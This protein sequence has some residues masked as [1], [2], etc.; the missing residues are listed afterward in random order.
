MDIKEKIKEIENIQ[1]GFDISLAQKKIELIDSLLTEIENSFFRD[2]CEIQREDITTILQY[3][4]GISYEIGNMRQSVN[5]NNDIEIEKRIL[6]IARLLFGRSKEM[7][8][9]LYSNLHSSIGDNELHDL[10]QSEILEI[11]Q[12]IIE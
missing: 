8:P 5:L 7:L 11:E 12:H 4:Y 3:C 2:I 1:V 6:P 9:Y 10:I